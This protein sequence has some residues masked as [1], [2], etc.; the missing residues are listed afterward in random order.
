MIKP[1]IGILHID[2][3]SSELFESFVNSVKKEQLSIIIQDRPGNTPYACPEWFIPAAV[4]AFVGKSY[5]DGFL[6]EMGK[7]HFYILKNH[8]S[9]LTNKLMSKPRIEPIM[10]GSKGK[11]STNNPF[12]NGLSIQSETNDGYALKLL[13]PK[14]D[15]NTDYS[16]HIHH[17]MMFLS[18]YHNGIRDLSSIGSPDELSA[19]QGGFVFVHYNEESQQIEW[20]DMFKYQ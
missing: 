4:V 1:D 10:M 11:L 14:A 5:F 18:D 17:F 7:D 19:I 3:L 2:S 13:L 8:L 6:K 16:M 20:V 9:E 15:G 12:S